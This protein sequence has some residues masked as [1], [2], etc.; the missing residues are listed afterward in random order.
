MKKIA[1]A[2]AA[3]IASAAMP[4][5]AAELIMNGNFEAGATGFTTTG[6]VDVLSGADYVINAGASGSSGAQSNHFA[7]FGSGNDA[8]TGVVFQSFATVAGAIYTL[9][10]EYGA[11]N[12]T[13]QQLSYS[14]TGVPGASVLPITTGTS[15]LDSLFTSFTTTFTGTGAPTTLR[16]ESTSAAGDNADVLLDNVSV[17][18]A[19]PEPGTWAMMLMGFAMV[20]AGLR[21]RRKPSARVTYA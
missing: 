6:N 9:S 17:T 21:G 13:S 5:Y 19:V 16:F 20:G 14:L 3:L 8:G 2:V 1:I 7:S 10:F 12:S 15:N 4:A 18:G 11:F